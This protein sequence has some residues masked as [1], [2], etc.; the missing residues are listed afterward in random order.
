MDGLSRR[1]FIRRGMEGAAAVTVAVPVLPALVGTVAGEAPEAEDSVAGVSA[2][3]PLVARIRDVA[4][5]EV[6][7]FLGERQV[8]YH[9]PALVTRLLQA[10]RK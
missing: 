6:E 7:L 8:T 5:G 10:S 2:A 3:E 4:S 1:V 9:D